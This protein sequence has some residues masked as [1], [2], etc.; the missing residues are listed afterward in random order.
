[1]KLIIAESKWLNDSDLRIDGK[2]HLS[3]GRVARLTIG[4]SPYVVKTIG[5]V[6]KDIFY[7]G[8]DRRVYVEDSSK[9]VPFMGISDMLKSDLN[10]LKYI[11]TKN[12]KNLKTYILHS[13]WTLVSRSGTIG[14]TVFTNSDYSDKAA[15][16]HIIRLVP[17][18]NILPGVLYA[19]LS[20]KYGYALLTQ[21][22]FGAVIQHIEPQFISELPIPDFPKSFQNKINEL[23]LKSANLKEKSTAALASA[24]QI[25]NENIFNEANTLSLRVGGCDYVT[26]CDLFQQRFDA[27]FYLNL[28]PIEKTFKKDVQFETL[29]TLVKKPMF[30]AQ[31][32][33]RVYVKRG[34]KFLS[35][36]DIA[37]SNP[38]RINKFLSL[39]TDGLKTLVVKKDWILVSSSGQE[40]LGSCYLVDNTY[41][42][43]AVNQHSIRVI[44]DEKKISPHYVF[45]FLSNPKVKDYIRAG[46]YGSAILTINED[47]LAMIKI[48]IL[49]VQLSKKIADLILSYQNCKEEA[50]R[51]EFEA[52][53]LIEKEIESWQK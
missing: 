47:Y 4:K 24:H 26:I 49:S 25:F 6:T 32:G 34:I 42:E 33:K 39:K 13:G 7:G 1:M 36:S 46:I 38:L 2:F 30:T 16:E 9:G 11:S 21:G 17:E 48:P 18:T 45:A 37:Q 5:S 50:C 35:T 43:C 27:S 12:T 19:Y 31:R 20:S 28:L 53:N 3:D 23:I 15:S 41:N 40:I 22:T 29:G 14:N 44:I 10:S 52:I 51:L 8:R